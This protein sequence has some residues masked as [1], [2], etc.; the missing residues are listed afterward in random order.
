MKVAVVGAGVAGLSLAARL[1]QN[2]FDVDVHSIL[3]RLFQLN[4]Q[5]K[6]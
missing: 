2:G 4:K 5:K 3:R 6:L 1:A